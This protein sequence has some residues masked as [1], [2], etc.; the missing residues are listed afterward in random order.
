M[1]ILLQATQGGGV[2]GMGST[3]LMMV[4]IIAVFYFF[5]IRPSRKNRKN[6]R[7]AAKR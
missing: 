1:N 2:T 6:C 5:M 7:K 4:A 3:L